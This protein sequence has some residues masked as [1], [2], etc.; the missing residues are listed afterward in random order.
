MVM[1]LPGTGFGMRCTI[2]FRCRR[3]TTTAW[4]S[5]SLQLEKTGHGIAVPGT[6]WPSANVP[7]RSTRFRSSSVRRPMPSLRAVGRVAA[8]AAGGHDEV[9]A[10]R[11]DRALRRIRDATHARGRVGHR[12]AEGLGR[13]REERRNEIQE[14][15]EAADG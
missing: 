8:D 9:P 1:A 3:Y 4:R 10:P 6:T 13:R 2:G 14:R 15:A 7:L 12:L 11:R 5:S